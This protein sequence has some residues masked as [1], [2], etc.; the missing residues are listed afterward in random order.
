MQN[1]PPY[2]QGLLLLQEDLCSMEVLQDNP[3]PQKWRQ[4][5]AKELETHRP[6]PHNLQNLCQLPRLRQWAF[7]EDVIC[8]A[9]KGFMPHDRVIEHNYALQM[10]LDDA[11]RS[12]KDVCIA[13]LDL[14]NAFG[15]VP[16]DLTM[17][18]LR[19][20]GLGSTGC[21]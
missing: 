6:V 18:V 14:S 11:R 19:R 10:Y 7:R 8:H 21:Q 1:P 9:Q 16:I 4:G 13:L 17:K 5:S 20:A 15:S 12:K 3:D 2:F